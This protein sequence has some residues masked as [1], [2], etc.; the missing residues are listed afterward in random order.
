MEWTKVHDL[1]L[2]EEI[3]VL[4][5]YKAKKGTVS[6]G[7]IWDKIAS[8]LN[9]LQLPR[10]KVT[11]RAVRER[12]TLLSDK[13]KAKMR[14]EEKASGIETEMSEVGKALEEISEKEAAAE[15]ALDSSKLQITRKQL[16]RG[17]WPWKVSV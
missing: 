4:E 3:L 15:D 5:P 16:K 13:F 14:E 10:F 9:S 8:N 11:K 17:T 2:C 1:C 12:Y 6:R 7:Q